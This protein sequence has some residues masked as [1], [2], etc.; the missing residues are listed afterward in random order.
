MPMIVRL[1]YTDGSEETVTGI[2]EIHYNFPSLV[3][4]IGPQIAFESD[5]RSTGFTRPISDI[6]EFEAKDEDTL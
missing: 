1:V 6:K 4:S 5:V 2:T 3:T